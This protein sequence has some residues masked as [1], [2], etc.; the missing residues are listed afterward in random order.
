MQVHRIT[1]KP[2][3]EDHL[4]LGQK[5]PVA[6]IRSRFRGGYACH[7]GVRILA[8]VHRCGEYCLPYD[9][10]VPSVFLSGE[11]RY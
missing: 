7:E 5:F 8:A 11:G 6:D 3:R 1:L 9:E 2:R 4:T 10:T